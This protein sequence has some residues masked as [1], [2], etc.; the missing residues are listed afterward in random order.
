MTTVVWPGEHEPLGATFD[1]AGTNFAIFS[2]P[3]SRVELCLFDEDGVETRLE[4]PEVTAF[5]H[6]GYV[7]G[8]QPGQRYG[9][10]V[11][12][13]WDPGNGHRCN[14]SKLLI[15]PYAKAIEGE[16]R[17]HPAVYGHDQP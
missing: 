12:G 6:H 9:F 8:V 11:Y 3:A 16:V 15:D 14:P 10:R 1:G 2:Q 13:P 5:V 4:L 7:H 17:R